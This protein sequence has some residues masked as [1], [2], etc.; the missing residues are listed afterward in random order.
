LRNTVTRLK[1]RSADYGSALGAFLVGDCLRCVE[2]LSANSTLAGTAL[3]ARALLR[4]NRY[5]DVI[6]ALSPSVVS[7]IPH[8][9]A[10][11]LL[12]I[13]A[14]ALLLSGDPAAE[15]V[16]TE[17]RARAFSSG[18]MPVECEV[19]FFGA[20]AAWTDDRADDALD[21]LDRLLEL[22][23]REPS[24][25]ARARS[26][27]VY[28]V[29]FWRARA[30]DMRGLSIALRGD[31]AGQADALACAFRE[32]DR[33][34]VNDVYFETRMLSNLA[35][36]VRDI[37]SDLLATYVEDRADLVSWGHHT[38]D[39]EFSVFQ[40]IG[41]NRAKRGDHLGAFR[42]L[43]RSA[44]CAPTMPLRINAILDRSFLA[45]EL[46]EVLTA[47]EELEHAVRLAKQVDWETVAS[48]ERGVLY[49]LA[50]QL[51]TN[52]AKQA[53]VLWDRYASLRSSVSTL[54]LVARGDRRQRADECSAHA[55]VLIAEGQRGRAISLLLESLDIWSTVGYAWR[56]AAVAADLAELTGESH[57]FDI[58]GREAAKQPNSWL[59]RR[60]ASI[61]SAVTA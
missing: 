54:S 53:R 31:Y 35:T 15:S 10:G 16:L 24:T 28:S 59:A 56:A 6:E 50:R 23:Q 2:G 7:D 9:Y 12:A 32:F 5:S 58:A 14:A 18:F 19:E 60:L 25:Y 4:M 22:S 11:E 8:E 52:D 30:H 36:L 3:R 20:L 46:G 26:D 34:H 51:A 49:A 17:A 61:K 39:A 37:D 33:A 47:G 21:T 38:A 42:N 43:R 1:P 41:W 13:K 48:S 55:A 40:A 44:N 57:Y 29:G 27:Y 45:R